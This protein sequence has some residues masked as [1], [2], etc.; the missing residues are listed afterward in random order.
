MIA[1]REVKFYKVMSN[2]SIVMQYHV[3]VADFG[4]L[5]KDKVKKVNT[6]ENVMMEDKS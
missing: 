2:E 4:L 1:I 3:L 5:L 6:G